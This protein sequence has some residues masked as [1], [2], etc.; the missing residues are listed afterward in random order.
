MDEST[1]TNDVSPEE[2]AA[3][4]GPKP[5]PEQGKT[6]PK[7][8]DAEYVKA[9]RKEAADHR[10]A[11]EAADTRLKELEDRDKTEVEKATARAAESERRAVEAEAKLLRVEVAAQKN[12]KAKAVP[13]L[14]GTTREEIEASADALLAFAKDNEDPTPDFD[15]GA[16]KTPAESKSPQ[17]A[18]NDFLMRVLKSES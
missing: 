15:G 16:R 11:R 10:K 9:L 18:H 12:L 8:P 17:E 14:H 2:P 1:P 6:T 4:D 13:L 3:S 5:E 7:V